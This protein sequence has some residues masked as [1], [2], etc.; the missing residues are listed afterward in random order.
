MR[1]PGPWFLSVEAHSSSLVTCHSSLIR[2]FYALRLASMTCMQ[3]GW[4]TPVIRRRDQD[5]VGARPQPAVQ[6]AGKNTIRRGGPPDH[7]WQAANSAAASGRPTP[8]A[9][10]RQ[11]YGRPHT[12]SNCVCR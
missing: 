6:Q 7:M 1:L 9:A 8:Q 5:G 2:Q 3:Q 10:P 11:R 12:R 4:L